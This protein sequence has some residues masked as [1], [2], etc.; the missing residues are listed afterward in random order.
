M[1][2]FPS[3]KNA[4]QAELIRLFSSASKVLS[5]SLYSCETWALTKAQLQRMESFHMK[6]LRRILGITLWDHIP[7]VNILHSCQISSISLMVQQARLRWLGRLGRM[8]DDRLPRSTSFGIPLH[9][10]RARG[11]FKS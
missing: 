10:S 9:G 4:K 3:L 1:W 11:R 5:R 7:N 6:C 2:A 8:P